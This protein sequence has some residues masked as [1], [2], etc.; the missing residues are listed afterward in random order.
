MFIQHTACPHCGGS[1]EYMPP[2]SIG[3]E[4]SSPPTSAA[5]VGSSCVWRR[6]SAD[7]AVFRLHSFRPLRGRHATLKIRFLLHTS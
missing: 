1:M 3:N 5:I 4:K 7:A 2:R 6:R